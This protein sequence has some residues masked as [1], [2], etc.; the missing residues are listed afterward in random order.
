MI[1]KTIAF[2]DIVAGKDRIVEVKMSGKGEGSG[3]RYC[4]G[5]WHERESHT[6]YIWSR[7]IAS[8]QGRYQKEAWIPW[9]V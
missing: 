2:V 5:C 6:E 9:F 8:L 7:G 4:D 1:F 3:S